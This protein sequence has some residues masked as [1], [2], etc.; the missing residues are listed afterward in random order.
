[1]GSYF[2]K[3]QPRL[4]LATS[5]FP[6]IYFTSLKCN[7]TKCSQICAYNTPKNIQ[8]PLF[9]GSRMHHIKWGPFILERRCFSPVNSHYFNE[10]IGFGKYYIS[11]CIYKL[12]SIFRV[13]QILGLYNAL[14]GHL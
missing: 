12:T 3:K 11:G 2:L 8:H 6:S 10:Q 13:N 1:M 5:Y 7:F 14:A 9:Q 4:H